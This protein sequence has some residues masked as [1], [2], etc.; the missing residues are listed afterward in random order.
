[1]RSTDASQGVETLPYITSM[2]VLAA[3]QVL[4]TR[5]C[6]GMGTYFV[7][8]LAAC[9]LCFNMDYN[10]V[11]MA[12]ASLPPIMPARRM[13]SGESPQLRL[14]QVKAACCK[15]LHAHKASGAVGKVWGVHQ[16]RMVQKPCNASTILE[17]LNLHRLRHALKVKVQGKS[18]W[19]QT[20]QTFTT[21][22]AW[23]SASPLTLLR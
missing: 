17:A 2:K 23:A 18:P 16:G 10:T 4:H 19:S 7:R 14:T 3:I 1:M 11:L 13:P 21:V 22:A 15:P 8:F 20:C 6:S 9:Y 5:S 12:L